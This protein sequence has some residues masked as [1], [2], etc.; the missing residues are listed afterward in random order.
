MNGDTLHLRDLPPADIL[1]QMCDQHRELVNLL[2]K[3]REIRHH[4]AVEEYQAAVLYHVAK[5]F[6]T[7]GG[8]AL[9]IG[10][11]RGYSAS[12]IGQAVA[13]DWL[14]TLNPDVN[15]ADTMQRNLGRFPNVGILYVKSGE[16]LT[17]AGFSTPKELDFIFVDGDH[18]HVRDDFPF[19]NRLRVGGCILFHD[20]SP[21]TS[22]R[23]CPPVYEGLNAMRE[24]LGREFDIAVIDAGG[25]GMAGFVRREGETWE[26][27]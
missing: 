27:K 3:A 1:Q 25:V 24:Q 9:E 15:E 4:K 14:I 20:Y 21:D 22:Y 16:F 6:H 7:P 8:F 23:A 19:F 11:A 26:V 13:P 17:S 2:W 18:K 10:T 5:H 12:L